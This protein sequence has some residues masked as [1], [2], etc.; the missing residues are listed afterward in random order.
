MATLRPSLI[1]LSGMMGAGKSKVAAELGT[2][3]SWESQDLD[4]IVEDILGET[5]A[6]YISVHGEQAFR[7]CESKALAQVLQLPRP[8]VLALGGGT[9]MSL[10][11]QRMLKDAGAFIVWLDVP[12]EIIYRRLSAPEEISKRPLLNGKDLYL[13]LSDRERKRRPWYE[14]TCD[15]R[16]HTHSMSASEVAREIE[17]KIAFSLESEEVE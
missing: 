17:R 6:S 9:L 12:L 15:L 8:L 1:A 11:N 16:I 2:L 5:L 14:S 10:E 7:F 13:A 4:S 3:L